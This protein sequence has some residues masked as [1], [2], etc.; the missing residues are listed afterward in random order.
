MLLKA[1]SDSLKEHS[2]GHP[3]GAIIRSAPLLQEKRKEKS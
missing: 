1:I 3:R 2:T